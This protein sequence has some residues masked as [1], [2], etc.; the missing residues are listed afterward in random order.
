MVTADSGDVFF[1]GIAKANY[2][3]EYERDF[4]RCEY[5]VPVQWLQTVQVEQAIQEAGMFD[6]PNP[7]CRPTTPQWRTTI[8][9]LKEHFAEFDRTL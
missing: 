3:R 6:N 2:H 5:F 4:D 9:R 1:L 7:V 8:E